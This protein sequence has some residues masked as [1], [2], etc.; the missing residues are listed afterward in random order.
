MKKLNVRVQNVLDS[1]MIGTKVNKEPAD[2]H[3]DSYNDSYYHDTYRDSYGDS[4]GD[5]YHD[6]Y[7][8][9]FVIGSVQNKKNVKQL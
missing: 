8:D 3:W 9:G 6:E 2:G 5:S 4:Y 7:R 1:A